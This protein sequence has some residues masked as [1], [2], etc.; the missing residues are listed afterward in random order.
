MFSWEPGQEPQ[1]KLS[2][3]ELIRSC[4]EDGVLYRVILPH[5]SDEYFS[6]FFFEADDNAISFRELA[7][8]DGRKSLTLD[9]LSQ[10]NI[11]DE[12]V[13]VDEHERE[14]VKYQIAGRQTDELKSLYFLDSQGMEQDWLDG[15]LVREEA[16]HLIVKKNKRAKKEYAVSKNLVAEIRF[17][18]KED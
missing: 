17:Y 14:W 16:Q 1:K 8:D 2:P 4:R 9:K 7:I 6:V 3:D 18:E 13:V 12:G 15:H 11:A 5:S 10:C